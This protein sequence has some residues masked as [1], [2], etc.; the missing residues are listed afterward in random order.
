MFF[1][2]SADKPLREQYRDWHLDNPLCSL[3]DRPFQRHKRKGSQHHRRPRGVVSRPSVPLSSWQSLTTSPS[4]A[5]FFGMLIYAGVI[6]HRH[7]KGTLR[8]DYT[9][10]N[11]NQPTAYQPQPAAYQNQPTSYY[12]SQQEPAK[13][14]NPQP[15]EME[16]RYA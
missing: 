3:H 12:G 16:N 9:P 10:A 1:D 15:Y 6:F 11:Q 5:S 14:Y 7:R 2:L 4:S 13:P 8:G